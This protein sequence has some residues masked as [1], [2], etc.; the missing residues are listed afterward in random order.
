[1][2]PS[3]RPLSK[4]TAPRLT[5]QNASPPVAYAAAARRVQYAGGRYR[6]NVKI[7]KT[8]LNYNRNQKSIYTVFIIALLS[9]LEREITPGR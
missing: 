2:S 6:C 5:S 3:A 9:S 7:I 1:M 4:K 8:I